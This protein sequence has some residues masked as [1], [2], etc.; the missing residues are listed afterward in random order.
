MMVAFIVDVF[1]TTDYT[2]FFKYQIVILNGMKCSE[3]SE[4]RKLMYTCL[5]IQ[6]LRFALDDTIF[7]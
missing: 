4:K 3:E 5:C 2:D 7:K 6:I 1:F